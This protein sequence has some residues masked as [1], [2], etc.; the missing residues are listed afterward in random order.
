MA[1]IAL[2]LEE[3]FFP[4]RVCQFNSVRLHVYNCI[5][6]LGIIGKSVDLRPVCAAACFPDALIMLF[7]ADVS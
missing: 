1:H 3:R 7:A 2:G 5:L 4:R 6:L